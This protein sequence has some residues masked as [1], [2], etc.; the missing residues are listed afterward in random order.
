MLEIGLGAPIVETTVYLC[1]FN[2]IESALLTKSAAMKIEICG[3][4][5]IT[6]A[7]AGALTYNYDLTTQLNETSLDLTTLFVNA[8]SN[9]PITSYRLVNVTGVTFAAATDIL[10]DW[11]ANFNLGKNAL[12]RTTLNVTMSKPG[13]YK[14]YVMAATD[15]MVVGFKEINFNMTL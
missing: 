13:Q 15:S 9:C 14:L 12:N 11:K 7:T 5:S 4:E 6:L 2:S 10:P 8:A 1:A 3:H